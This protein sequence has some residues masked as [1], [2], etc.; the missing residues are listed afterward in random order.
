ML[1][2]QILT[3]SSG[4]F[5]KAFAFPSHMSLLQLLGFYINKTSFFSFIK[6]TSNFQICPG[7]NTLQKIK[8]EFVDPCDQNCVTGASEATEDKCSFFI[9]SNILNIEKQILQ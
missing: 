7:K 2:R 9:T 5:L 3:F 8:A 4:A 6:T 1:L